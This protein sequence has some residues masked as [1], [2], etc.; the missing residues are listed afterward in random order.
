MP[1]GFALKVIPSTMQ[2]GFGRDDRDSAT[3][4]GF[5]QLENQIGASEIM[6]RG[7]FKDLGIKN[8]SQLRKV[9]ET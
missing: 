3:L 2:V 9:W 5:Q 1:K 7:G 8:A 6:R 4:R